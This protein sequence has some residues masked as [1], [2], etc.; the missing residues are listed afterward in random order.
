MILL[1]C[2]SLFAGDPFSVDSAL[3][4]PQLA[5]APVKA[6]QQ[7]WKDGHLVRVR[8]DSPR[9][10]GGELLW[11]LL[12]WA[13]GESGW[14]EIDPSGEVNRD[15]RPLIKGATQSWFLQSPGSVTLLAV[16][17]SRAS[18]SLEFKAIPKM[19]PDVKVPLEC[20]FN[21]SL[22]PFGDF[23]LETSENCDLNFQQTCRLV[24]R[25]DP[26]LRLEVRK[27][28]LS[29]TLR[30]PDADPFPMVGNFA[31]LPE[32]EKRDQIAEY[33]T[34][35]THELALAARSFL[36]T[37]PG[38]FNWQVWNWMDWV[39]DGLVSNAE[40]RALLES[41]TT[42]SHMEIYRATCKDGRK[43]L[44]WSDGRGTLGMEL[45]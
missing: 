7:E 21:G 4:A 22:N 11:A 32:Q 19:S 29:M 24:H 23:I 28:G 12:D 35:F 1:L 18:A 10:F 37:T 9:A 38:I 15:L 2:G 44:F 33:R 36:E 34:Y 25:D 45:K 43:L 31:Q 5:S 42:P 40:I 16:L 27:K 14:M 39:K 8:F 17:R 6:S 41:G 30:I 3:V 20:R 13:A 26:R